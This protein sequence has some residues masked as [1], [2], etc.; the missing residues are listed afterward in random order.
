VVL[1]VHRGERADALAAA[2][3]EL[4]AAPP[5]DPFAEDV[6]AVPA[7]GVERWLAQRL[8]HRL[9]AGAGGDG[10]CAGVRFPSPRRL[11]A[12]AAGLGEHDPWHPDA[13][14]WPLLEVL[15]A[16]A[17][18][19]WCRTLGTHLG[20][21]ADDP[22]ERAHRRGRRHAVAHRLARLLD[23][24]ATH[25]P[26]LVAAWAEGRDED[27]LGAPLPADLAWQP[28]LWRLLRERVEGPDPVERGALVA[29]RLRRDP[30]GAPL[31]ERLSVFGPTRLAAGERALLLALAEHRDVHLWLP[32]PS[33]DLWDRAA[34][35]AARR[36]AAV[37]RR[38]DA[39]A[40]LA[41][42]PLL[43]ALGRDAR[44]LALTLGGVPHVAHHHPAP[45]PPGTLLG[46]LQRD[47]RADR[48]PSPADRP[49]LGADDRSV[50]VHACHGRARQVE[51]LREVLV[52]LLADDPTLEPRDVLVMCPDV[53]DYAP[54]VAAG[55]GLS[56]VSA[57]AHPAHGLRVRLADRALR[58]T[59]P[60]LATAAR[61][62][63]LAGAR[64]T[65]SE[66][67]DLAARGP[68]RRRFRLDDDDLETLSAWVGASGV[69]WGLDAAHRAP[70]ALD[71]V[72]QNTWRAGLDR[73]LLGAAMA[74]EDG[75]RLGL[76]LPLDDVGSG[77]VALAGRLAELVDRL[78]ATLAALAAR[79]ERP[80]R[81]WLGLLREGVD[82][83]TEVAPAD[84]WQA[85]ELRRVLAEVEQAAGSRAGSVPLALADVRS[86][87]RTRLGGRPTRANFR[88]GTLTVCT[89]VPMRSV[90][91]R[92]VCLLGLD[93]GAFPRG[94][95][96]DGDDVLDRD[97]AVGEPD[98]RAEDR[99]L[100]LDALLAATERVVVT[101]TGAD[102][103]TGARR[104]PSVPLGELLD[105]LD[106]TAVAADGRAVREHV[107]V[108]HPLQPFDARCLV[109][110]SLGRPG[111]AFSH[112]R[113]ALAGARAARGPRV[114]PAPFL[115]APLPPPAG[116]PPGR[117]GGAPAV[118]ELADVTDLLVHPA[119]GF[120]RQRLDV[121]VL[122]EEPEPSDRLAVELD[123]LEAWAVGD[124]VLRDRLA[125]GSLEQAR[126]AEWRR[127]AL[128][129]GGLGARALDRV[130]RDVEPLVEGTAAL[131]AAP[132]RS[133]DVTVALPGGSELRG[134]VAGVRGTTLV[135]VTYSKLRAPHRLRAWVGLL[136]LSAAH[137][138]T[139]WTAATVGRGSGRPRQALVGPVA[140]GT[141]RDLLDRLV[142]LHRRGLRAPLPLPLKAGAAY[143]AARCA[144]QE[145]WEAVDRARREW[146]GGTYPGEA[147]E[148][149]H[150]RVHGGAVPLER[151]LA[152]PPGEDE[153][154]AGE[155][156]RLGELAVRL[157]QPLLDLERV[158]AL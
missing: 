155:P 53:E 51:V 15:D 109:P 12:E 115:P 27:G 45:A 88:T 121:A 139:A 33:G 3:A 52:G 62:L 17:G 70:Y 112:D 56:D 119:R 60:L 55:F 58:Q 108:R 35:L 156:T 93:D 54:L 84:L 36:P 135:E 128:P 57:Q 105:A 106:E 107:E 19:D 145:P 37:R 63:E 111:R 16:C 90:P 25:R 151:L 126:Q 129:P 28:R 46:H 133:V 41:R 30:A 136:A 61:L 5:V 158:S 50:Q 73:I 77:E 42:H 97:P 64:G 99:Q 134:T 22:A 81:A 113:S 72:P 80:L 68:V 114:E 2:L 85:G 104:P 143:A 157:W 78:H 39:T 24:A 154:W 44:E 142:D 11:L 10:V 117:A 14:V 8:A 82:G 86:L 100:L 91:H 137:P 71:L 103:R 147:E 153:R 116:A 34:A 125:G 43:S 94:V 20:V 96:R 102:E 89:M 47:L 152:E 122:Q 92:V 140:P 76:A 67:L 4:L 40:T 26:A 149:A 18:E 120:L 75:N 150:L 138:G 23:A 69:R 95:R 131:R 9:G 79:P 7:R 59:N 123:A 101:Y 32:H 148:P 29:D 141:A 132:R 31:P 83:L 130:L 74:D 98:P 49:V 118:V 146:E 127:G 124:R 38:D 66:V 110:G 21:D 48:R 6:V 87:L 1:H 144:G 13:L 65:A